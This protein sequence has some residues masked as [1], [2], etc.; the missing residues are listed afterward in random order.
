MRKDN[1]KISIGLIICFVVF[2]ILINISPRVYSTSLETHYTADYGRFEGELYFETLINHSSLFCNKHGSP[3]F[4]KRETKVL[5]EGQVNGKNFSVNVSSGGTYTIWSVS[6]GSCSY[7]KNVTMNLNAVSFSGIGLSQIEAA[8]APTKGPKTIYATGK[9]NYVVTGGGSPSND[10]I[11]YLLNEA[12]ANTRGLKPEQSQPNIAWWNKGSANVI[13][14]D[15]SG[16]FDSDYY[17][18]ESNAATV[19]K[20]EE[21]RKNQISDL[22]QKIEAFEKEKKEEQDIL[23]ELQGKTNEIAQFE[24]DV[25]ALESENKTLQSEKDQYSKTISDYTT[26]INTLTSEISTLNSEIAS[27]ESD[28]QDLNNTLTDLRTQKA[29]LEQQRD[30]QIAAGE[31]VTDIEDQIDDVNTSIASTTTELSQKHSEI[32][33]KNSTIASKNERISL[34]QQA[35]VNLESNVA[36]ITAKI[37]ANNAEIREKKSLI[38]N[39]NTGDDSESSDQTLKDMI[40]AKKSTID[41]ID[42]QLNELNSQKDKINAEYDEK[43]K[44]YTSLDGISSSSTDVSNKIGYS[45]YSAQGLLEEAR[46]FNTMHKEYIKGNYAARIKDNSNTNSVLVSYDSSTRKYTVGPFNISYIEVYAKQNQFAGITGTPVLTMS[47]N[48]KKITKNLG[49]GWTFGYSGARSTKA[50]TGDAI[51]SSFNTY[52]HTGENFYF[53]IDYEEGLEKVEGLQLTFRHLTA[54]GT[55]EVSE[56][57]VERWQWTVGSPSFSKC[58]K[59]LYRCHHDGED[60]DGNCHDVYCQ[61]YKSATVS[62]TKR[63]AGEIDTQPIMR[64]VKADRQYNK[65]I[66]GGYGGNVNAGS[67]FYWGIDL[68]TTLAGDVWGEIAPQKADGTREGTIVGIKDTKENGVKNVIVTVYVSDGRNKK[69]AIAHES[70]GTAKQAKMTTSANGH[71]EF[72]RIEAPGS[73]TNGFYI[74]EFQYDGQ[75][76]R[77]T[78]FL[79]DSDK[80]TNDVVAQTTASSYK[81][82]SAHY[83]N[84]SMAVETVAAR[85]AFDQSFGEITGDTPM[86]SNTTNGKTYTTNRNGTGKGSAGS[87]LYKGT[88]ADNLVSSELQTPANTDKTVDGTRYKMTAS[89]YYDDTNAEG[90]I[91]NKDDFRIKYPLEGNKYT[92]NAIKDGNRRYISTY[93]LHINL[94]LQGR[95]YTDMSVLKDLYKVTMVVNEQKITKQFNSLATT[96]SGSLVNSDYN[97]SLKAAL[98]QRKVGGEDKYK[99]SLGLYS[100]DVAYQSYQRYK[101]AIKEVTDLKKGTELKVYVTY[102]VRVYNN[103]ETNDVEINDIADYYDKSYTL[104]TQDVSTS[105]VDEKLNRSMQKVADAPYYR[106]MSTTKGTA[107]NVWQDTKE[108]NF[109]GIAN[110]KKGD[111]KWNADNQ[112]KNN[113][114]ESSSNSIDGKKIHTNEYVEI[115]TT[116]E[117][118]QE[119]Y[120]K[121]QSDEAKIS[122]RESLLGE[123]QNVAEIKSYSTFYTNKDHTSGDKMYAAFDQGWVSG[124]VDKDSAPD[125]I[126][127]SKINDKTQYEDDTDRSIPL[128]ISIDTYERDMYGY[129]WEDEK[130]IDAGTEIKVGNGTY[131]VGEKKIENVEASM[132][133]VINLG[134]LN[135]NGTYNASYDSFD[136]YYKVPS[137]FYNYSATNAYSMQSENAAGSKTVVTSKN[138]V[139]DI[140]GNMVNGNYYIYGFLAGDYILRFDYG[141]KTSKDTDATIYSTDQNGETTTRQEQFSVYNGQDYENTKFLDGQLDTLN[142]KY[143]D[144]TAK[145][146]GKTFIDSTVS[147]ARDNESRRMVVDAYSRT[148]ENDRGEILRDRNSNEFIESTKMFAETPIMQIEI[149]N[150]RTLEKPTKELYQEKVELNAVKNQEAK[151]QEANNQKGQTARLEQHR[152]TIKNINF[153]LEERAKTDIELEKYIESI[154]MIKSGEVIFAANM[155]ENGEVIKEDKSASH[156]DKLTYLSHEKASTNGLV[157]QGFYAIAVEDD[158]LNDLTLKITYKIK[159]INNSEIDYTGKLA[160][161]YR[162]EDIINKAKISPTDEFTDTVIN[163]IGNEAGISSSATLSEIL[164]KQDSNLNNIIDKESEDIIKPKVIIYGKYVGRFY[165]EN[166]ISESASEEVIVNSYFGEKVQNQTVEYAKVKYPADQLVKTTV[167]QIVDYIDIDA[168]LDDQGLIVDTSWQL[169]GLEKEANGYNKSLNGLLSKS[170]YRKVSDDGLFN[171]Y[172]DKDREYINNTRSNIAISYNERLNTF[173]ENTG[174]VEYISKIVKASNYNTDLTRELVPVA[175]RGTLLSDTYSEVRITVAKTASSGTDANQMKI[176]NLAEVLVYSNP[177]GRRDTNSVPGNAMAIVNHLAVNNKEQGVWYAGYNS[178]GYWDN[179]AIKSENWTQYPENDAWSPEYVTIIAPTGIALRTY[180][181]QHIVPIVIL[182]GT[183]VIMMVMFGVKQVQIFRKRKE[184]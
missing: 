178:A 136:Y 137:E 11:S 160:N 154:S 113:I 135:S 38:S 112:I 6:H 177:T 181:R 10:A 151:N 72:N 86:S 144:L 19:K 150:P 95:A 140:D 173:D 116:Y 107:N 61:K 163:Y 122:D 36:S 109:N 172:D 142:D 54:S 139:T 162:A 124:K 46:I 118:D 155:L 123:K 21:E 184:D 108:K 40:D 47:K 82:N 18:N 182:A 12:P 115:F 39:T 169:S 158:Y 156:L 93:M 3:F 179:K 23:N 85:S 149:E 166:S 147:K 44:Y 4:I 90:L 141:T 27:L 130:N 64:V 32:A 56:G 25:K 70:N 63:R 119:G 78:V 49:D 157:Q 77:H 153:G 99:Y 161:M 42:K 37:N 126:D 120:L 97:A 180:I 22:D 145:I 91:N 66:V 1:I 98:E 8:C 14:N 53:I 103:S 101:D 57:T 30:E 60:D 28:V 168:S 146:D 31:D 143:L 58:H 69:V 55:Y 106:I 79:G 121:M 89:T 52:P 16:Y 129:V 17:K 83:L 92:L 45:S 62:V 183:I 41:S 29:D 2:V 132:Y 9:T 73:Y 48:G 165:Y 34:L 110:D 105:I 88:K 114:K 104:V 148:I 170:S 81:N 133:E 43:I 164:A 171:I 20:L 80:V 68:T 159:V 35:I 67:M 152:Y 5:L 102:V 59:F 174:R 13:V 84:S 128:D 71:Y 26:E 111:F 33:S 127:K 131:E 51:P 76:Y 74:I 167:D 87:L 117:V 134:K 24:E 94:G 75:Q 15:G 96:S 7:S 175:Y 176:D 138:N 100:T 65:D 125:N 50:T